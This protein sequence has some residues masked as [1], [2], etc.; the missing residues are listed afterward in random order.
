M[1][2][3]FLLIGLG[4]PNAAAG[5]VR[6]A[7][8]D[9]LID[10]NWEVTSQANGRAALNCRILSEDGTYRPAI[11]DEIIIEEDGYIE[12]AGFI[13]ATLEEGFHDL[14]LPIVTDIDAGDY[15]AL[16]ARRYVTTSIPAGSTLKAALQAIV[17][18]IPHVTLHPGQVDGPVVGAFD[19][20][21]V[22]TED[23][24]NELVALLPGWV[25]EV[26]TSKQLRM[27]E[28]STQAAPFNIDATT[29]T[30]NKVTVEPTRDGYANRVI[31]KTKTVRKTAEDSSALTN[32]WEL[33]VT[34]PDTTT[35][36]ALQALADSIL[37][38][39][40]P[41]LKRIHYST[42][43]PGLRPGQTQVINLPVRNVNN[44]FLIT[45]VVSRSGDGGDYI[46]RAVTAVEGLVTKTGW[47]DTYKKWNAGGTTIG[48]AVASGGGAGLT[49]FAYFLG[50]SGVEAVQSATPDWVP[51][52]GGPIPGTGSVQVQINTVPRGTTQAL[53]TA[54][55]RAYKAGV[56]VKA[57]LWDVTDSIPCPGESLTVVTDADLKWKTVT[58]TVT[59]TPGSHFYE[60]QLLPG[61]P[62]EAVYG[63]AYVE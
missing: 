58:F 5:P 57:R 13:T 36:T 53:I 1:S 60:L 19:W 33:I 11:D 22:K 9:R 14:D 59:L 31:V 15:N 35:D 48:G 38:Q 17:P 29:K 42:R 30:I 63:V 24:L 6:I 23:V 52:C 50:G 27:V 41:A 37:A 44:T 26:N 40:L 51:V 62:N 10:P 56:S 7:G 47:R 16:A 46:E 4:Q 45:D 2:V 43:E 20:E 21:D 18:F 49:R 39:S 55:L 54:R 34:A 61:A 3:I 32:P 25:W 8:I 12:F 28:S